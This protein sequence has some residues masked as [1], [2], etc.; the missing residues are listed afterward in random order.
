MV[1]ATG[2]TRATATAIATAM[3][4]AMVKLDCCIIIVNDIE[5]F[6]R[7][8]VITNYIFQLITILVVDIYYIDLFY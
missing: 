4:M 6:Q 3:A 8:P 5:T 2:S 7:Q 1:K